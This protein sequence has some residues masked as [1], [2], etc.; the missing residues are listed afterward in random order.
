M[1]SPDSQP[2]KDMRGLASVSVAKRKRIAGMGGKAS[3]AKGT[4]HQWDSETARKASLKGHK[5][6]WKRAREIQKANEIQH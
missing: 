3:H 2:K 1:E 4:A 5:A 6:R